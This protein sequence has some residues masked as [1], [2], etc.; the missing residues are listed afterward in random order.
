MMAMVFITDLHT[1]VKYLDLFTQT[2]VPLCV[3]HTAYGPQ[4]Q[5][6][7]LG[8]NIHKDPKQYT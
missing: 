7:L 1:E 4:C 8:S 3:L 5:I 2:L 6:F